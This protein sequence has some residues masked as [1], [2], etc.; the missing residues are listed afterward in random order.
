[1]SILVVVNQFLKIVHLIPIL[2]PTEAMDI[3]AAFF[4]SVV[5][6]HSLPSTIILEQDPHF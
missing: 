4:E 3:A 5:H 2:F 1:M 6:L